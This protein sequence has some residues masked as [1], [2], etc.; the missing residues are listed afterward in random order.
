MGTEDK[1]S[2]LK[3]EPK[4]K[5][6][7]INQDSRRM[8]MEKSQSHCPVPSNMSLSISSSE[9]LDFPSHLQTLLH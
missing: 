6:K 9:F 1:N 2:W 8:L 7:L 3:V 4:R 5:N